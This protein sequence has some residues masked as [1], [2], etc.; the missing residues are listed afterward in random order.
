MNPSI[1]LLY[2]EMT[3]GGYIHAALI[4]LL[5]HLSRTRPSICSTW[6]TL[7]FLKGQSWVRVSYVMLLTSVLSKATTL[8]YVGLLKPI[9]T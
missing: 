8:A 6:F 4:R 5:G 1:P 3:W 2:V 7:E 9:A